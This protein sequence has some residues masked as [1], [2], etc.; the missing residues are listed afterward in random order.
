[1]GCLRDRGERHVANRAMPWDIGLTARL[2]GYE[3]EDDI[4]KAR[5][6]DPGGWMARCPSGSCHLEEWLGRRGPPHLVGFVAQRMWD[7]A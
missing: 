1:M 4:A 2:I 6:C 7:E 3:P 5:E